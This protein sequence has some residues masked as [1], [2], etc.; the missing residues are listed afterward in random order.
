MRNPLSMFHEKS[1]PAAPWSM[2][3]VIAFV[4]AITVN[5]SLILY[6]IG[7]VPANWPLAFVVGCTY[8]AMPLLRLFTAIPKWFD[9]KPF[10]DAAGAML[11][12]LPAMIPSLLGGIPGTTAIT[13]TLKSTITTP[14][15]TADGAPSTTSHPSGAG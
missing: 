3:R 14:A 5:A 13:E 4:T 10:R 2:G 1:D 6:A 11:A 9:S 15:A 8:A 7:R 12:K